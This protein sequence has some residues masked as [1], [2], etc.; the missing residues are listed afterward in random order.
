MRRAN[1]ACLPQP[2]PSSSAGG[3]SWRPAI[4]TT[5]SKAQI[6]RRK[7]GKSFHSAKLKKTRKADVGRSPGKQVDG[8]E[9]W[10]AKV[11]LRTKNDTLLKDKKTPTRHTR[12][13][14]DAGSYDV[15]RMD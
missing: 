3:S 1:A 14:K 7:E 4:S 6:E 12:A 10:Y 13:F 5:L 11:Y 15:V 2:T 8:R 9:R